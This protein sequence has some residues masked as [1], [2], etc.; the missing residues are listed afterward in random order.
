MI[1]NDS[2]IIVT[3]AALI[4]GMLSLLMGIGTDAPSGENTKLLI[5]PREYVQLRDTLEEWKHRHES[6]LADQ[7]NTTLG[8]G[9]T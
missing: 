3:N 6:Y 1:D 2:Y 9:T 8:N 4:R 7:L 5:T